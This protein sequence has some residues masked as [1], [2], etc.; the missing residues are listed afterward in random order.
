MH[1][2]FT[3]TRTNY[4]AHAGSNAA[5]SVRDGKST[6]AAHRATWLCGHRLLKRRFLHAIAHNSEVAGRSFLVIIE[7]RYP[8]ELTL[9][10]D[11]PAL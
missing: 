1:G 5:V 4:L 9:S 8:D 6:V 11:F 3:G 7:A 10:S 2:E